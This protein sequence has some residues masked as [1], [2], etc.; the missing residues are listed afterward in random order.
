MGWIMNTE[1][2][3]PD[4]TS[5]PGVEPQTRAAP[6]LFFQSRVRVINGQNPFHLR[7]GSG[8]HILFHIVQHGLEWPEKDNHEWQYI[9]V[10]LSYLI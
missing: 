7:G 9:S 2:E 4:F 5:E 6:T 8:L 3:K 10:C 1:V